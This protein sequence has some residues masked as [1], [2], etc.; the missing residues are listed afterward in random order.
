MSLE[1]LWDYKYTNWADISV[2]NYKLL[3][4]GLCKNSFN[5]CLSDIW[6]TYVL[7]KEWAGLLYDF[8]Q[9]WHHNPYYD[10]MMTS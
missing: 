1:E 3:T 7:I 9:K 4:W 10:I 2:R 5:C 6:H 8:N